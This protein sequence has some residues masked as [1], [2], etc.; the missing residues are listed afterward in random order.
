M[1]QLGL[2][3]QVLRG[4][5]FEIV[6]V[7]KYPMLEVMAMLSFQHSCTCSALFK[8]SINQYLYSGFVGLQVWKNSTLI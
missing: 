2:L 3:A 6:T 5:Y 7:L 8:I 4:T 1:V